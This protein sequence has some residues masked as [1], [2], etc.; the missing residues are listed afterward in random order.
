[1]PNVGLSSS[2]AV[3]SS[4]AKEVSLKETERI[5]DR[6]R[7]QSNLLSHQIKTKSAQVCGMQGPR[8]PR[9][10]GVEPGFPR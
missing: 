6:L 2:F 10:T 4:R 9:C 5:M 8:V 1:M 7:A 3:P